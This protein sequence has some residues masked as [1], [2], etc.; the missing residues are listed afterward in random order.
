MTNHKFGGARCRTG[1]IATIE[2][3]FVAHRTGHTLLSLKHS[4]LA[5]K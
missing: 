3:T 1:F 2:F 4:A 5:A